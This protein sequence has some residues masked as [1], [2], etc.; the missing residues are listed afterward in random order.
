MTS[1]QIKSSDRGCILSLTYF[2]YA[3]WWPLYKAFSYLDK[4]TLDFLITFSKFFILFTTSEFWYP[5]PLLMSFTRYFFFLLCGILGLSGVQS[6]RLLL[7]KQ[8][9]LLLPSHLDC[10]SFPPPPATCLIYLVSLLRM[11]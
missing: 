7:E 11:F 1:S 10:L 3:F 8:I 4:Y 6:H 9:M 2:K 5:D